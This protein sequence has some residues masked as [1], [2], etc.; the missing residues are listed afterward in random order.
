MQKPVKRG[1]TWRITV[2]YLGKRYTTTRDTASECEQWA[3]KKLL[4]L[5]SEQANPESE[6]SI[7]PFMPFLNSTI[8]KKAEK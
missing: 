3:T 6:K 2:R 7:S 1:D 4:E 5:Q 8:K